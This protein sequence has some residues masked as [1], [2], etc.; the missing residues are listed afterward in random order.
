MSGVLNVSEMGALALHS[1]LEV[2]KR[3]DE[4]VRSWVS[5]TELADV[6]TA[7]RH[8]LHKVV[9]RLV[10]AGFLESS[11]GPMGGVKLQRPP[12]QIRLIEVMEAVDGEFHDGGCLFARRVCAPTAL[13]QFCGITTDLEKVVRDYFENTTMADL[14]SRLRAEGVGAFDLAKYQEAKR[15]SVQ[16][17]V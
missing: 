5:V 7:S 13:C 14:T 16:Q 4:G 9:K 8:T 10:T 6:L 3:Y 1:L 15:N 11:R 2:S 12:S 17:T